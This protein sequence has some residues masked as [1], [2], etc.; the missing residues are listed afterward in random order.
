MLDLSTSSSTSTLD[1]M[2]SDYNSQKADV[3]ILL[4]QNFACQIE[5][6]H[7]SFV[8]YESQR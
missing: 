2:R 7:I 5:M 3:N 8:N 6:M 1:D 4:N